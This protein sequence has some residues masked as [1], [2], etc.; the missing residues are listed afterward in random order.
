M[1]DLFS[2]LGQKVQ[3]VLEVYSKV[4]EIYD[5]HIR[6]ETHSEVHGGM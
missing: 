1:T 4:D 3:A 5:L 2:T 6:L